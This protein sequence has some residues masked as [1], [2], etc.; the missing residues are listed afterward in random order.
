LKTKPTQHSVNKLREIGIQPDILL[1]RTSHS[2]SPELKAKIALFCNV[3]RDA[4]ITAKDVECVYEV[5]LVFHDEGLDEK[6]VKL[7][8]IWTR[9]PRLEQ[10]ERMVSKVKSPKHDVTIGIVGKYVDLQDS[11]KSLHEALVHGGIANGC[12][13]NLIYVDSEEI[14]KN[15]ARALLKDVDAI[16]VPGGFGSR[17]IE[18]KIATI[19]YAREKKIPFFGICLGMQLS[20]IE[21]ARNLCGLKDANSSEFNVDTPHPVIDM[22]LEQRSITAKGGTMRLGAYPCVLKKGSLAFKAYGRL[23]ISERHRHRYEVNNR[24]RDE[25]EKAGVV[26]SGLSPDNSLVEIME[27]KNHPW[28]LGCQFH[29]EFKSRPMHPH[30]LFEEFIKAALQRKV[31]GGRVGKGKRK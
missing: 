3:D 17:G 25:M 30:P 7:L 12:R 9:S 18:G 15:G 2:L 4:V 24:Y 27:Y 5:P 28:F 26:F 11:Y 31:G 22:M 14:E 19:Q 20:A 16:L 8:N 1:C 23:E 6:V 10:W 21:I 13:V 29:P